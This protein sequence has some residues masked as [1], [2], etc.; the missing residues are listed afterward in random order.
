MYKNETGFYGGALVTPHKAIAEAATSA[1][2]RA[3]YM[4][5][6]VLGAK[7]AK[8]FVT[9]VV[10]SP[11]IF[12]SIVYRIFRFGYLHDIRAINKF[13]TIEL[14]TSRKSAL[15]ESYLRRMLPVQARMVLRQLGKVA[16][17]AKRRQEYSRLYY[18]ELRDLPELILPPLREDGSCVYNYFPIQYKDRVALVRW[19]M[20]HRRD[21]AVQ[22]LKNCA[23]LDSFAPE[24]RA[25]PNAELTADE[26]I[27]LPNYPAYG[28]HSVRANIAA[29]RTFF[30]A[31]AGP[32]GRA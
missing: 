28:E 14:D 7:A 4:S 20:R 32:N 24:H 27:L 25:C 8:A 5:L 15:P 19:M 31:G 16:S 12:R 1:L 2:S 29:I 26:V 17:D 9:D 21:V 30:K 11:P 22:H 3:P 10:T 6:G 18:E 13:V 23:G